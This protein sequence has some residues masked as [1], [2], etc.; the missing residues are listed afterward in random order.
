LGS[1]PDHATRAL[2]TVKSAAKDPRIA[3]ELAKHE[4]LA[5]VRRS[6]DAAQQAGRLAKIRQMMVDKNW[7]FDQAFAEVC[8]QENEAK[9][10]TAVSAVQAWTRIEYDPEARFDL[11]GLY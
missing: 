7:N 3:Q 6:G 4:K 10:T 8:R 5:D 9:S 2:S 1:P 11:E